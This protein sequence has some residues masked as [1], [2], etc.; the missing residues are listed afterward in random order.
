MTERLRVKSRSVTLDATTVTDSESALNPIARTRTMRRPAGTPASENRPLDVETARS[1]DPLTV[2]RAPGI[3]APLLS[4]TFPLTVPVCAVNDCPSAATN[5]RAAA[6][7]PTRRMTEPSITPPVVWKW[8]RIR[9]ARRTR[10]GPVRRTRSGDR[11]GYV[12]AP[13]P[14]F[15]RKVRR[16]TAANNA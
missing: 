1:P 7:I 14:A 9:T 4:A 10:N 6:S 11:S 12:R 15:L 8:F 2:S 16:W 5:S 13:A 3:K